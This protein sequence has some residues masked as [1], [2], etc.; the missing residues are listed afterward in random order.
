MLRTKNPL[1]YIGLTATVLLSAAPLYFMLVMASRTTDE[2]VS[3]PPPLSLGGRLFPNLDEVFANP[4]VL[5]GRALVNSFLVATVATVCVVVT[6]SLAGF[7]F[8]K[9]RFKGRNILLLFVIG[10]M[11][12]PVQ[13]GLIP[14]YMLM[15]KLGLNG[16]LESVTLPF[17]VAG[18]GVFMMRQ[19]AQQAIPDEMI[20]AARVDGASTFRIFF[21]IVFPALRPAAAVLGLLTFMERWNDF[22]WP[23]LTLDSEH[24]T[25]QVALSRL[26]SGYY[27]DQSLIMAGTFIGT[28]PLVVVFI[29]FGRQI[30][31]GIMEGGLKA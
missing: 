31:G 26:S 17:V 5:F 1:L 9:L 7:A 25:V 20:E 3:L 18:F 2:I 22:L 28:L 29:V 23:Y 15:T 14:L 10:T 19:F 30:I 16:G 6:S 8:A 11:M 24:P 27:S 4:D 12:V 21:S 13:L